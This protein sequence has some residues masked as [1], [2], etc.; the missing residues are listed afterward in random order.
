MREIIEQLGIEPGIMAVNVAG[1]LLLLWLLRKF[2]WGPLR[3]VLAQREAE[4]EQN[5]GQADG[6]REAAERDR[7]TLAAELAQSDEKAQ[8][9]IA[10]GQQEAARQQAEMIGEARQESDRLAAQGR[11]EVER[12]ADEARQQLRAEAAQLAVEISAQAIKQSVDE[13]RQ[14]ALVDAF[15]EELEQMTAPDGGEGD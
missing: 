12:A 15:I 7:R 2:A 13:E 10:R 6:L 9:I 5:L 11:R 8:E 3:E 14:A 1:F 4:V